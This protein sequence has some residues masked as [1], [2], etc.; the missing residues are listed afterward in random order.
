M[1]WYVKDLGDYK[2]FKVSSTFDALTALAMFAE[3]KTSQAYAENEE[4]SIEYIKIRDWPPFYMVHYGKSI[5]HI[6]ANT[7]SIIDMSGYI[8]QNIIEELKKTI[9][10]K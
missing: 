9:R 3:H 4:A 2:A 6:D 7:A 10:G 1:K 5:A 8:P